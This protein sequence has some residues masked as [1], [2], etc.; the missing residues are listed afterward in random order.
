MHVELHP[1]YRD[2]PEA[3]RASELIS[4]CVHCG[5]CLATCPTYL[6]TADERDSP[7]GRIYLVKQLL[8][9]GTASSATRTHLDR[10]L[11]CRSCETTCPSGMQYGSLVDIGRGMLEQQVPRPLPER[12]FRALL[13][14][15]LTRPALFS[16][17]LQLGRLLAPL[18][19]APLAGKIPPRQQ[20]GQRP[21]AVHSRRVLLL[22][23][24]VQ[25]AATPTTNAALAR[26]LDRLGISL[27]TVAG[28][29]CCGAVNYHLG[30]H[31]DGLDNM[32]RNIDAWWPAVDAGAEA[33][34][35]SA[36]GCGS[37][38][39]DYGQLLAHDPAYADRARRIASLS[40]DAA[41][42]LAG[43][44][45]QAL[46]VDS[47]QG[48]VAVHTPCSQ[49]HGLKQPRLVQRILSEA[50]FELSA[51]RDDHLCCG[52]AGTYSILQRER[53]ER[54][55][56]RKLRALETGQPQ[57]IVTANVGCQ[58]HL[59]EQSRAPVRHWLELLDPDPDRGH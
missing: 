44:D 48:P 17:L 13:R 53:S 56:E 51:T 33:I 2:K 16:R 1:S 22:E 43:E 4:A 57:L 5:F 11:T 34:V 20:P 58:L 31:A 47:G 40:R 50:G 24:C 7:R 49:Y 6:D 30:A 46:A 37:L 39:A 27:E 45:L 41:E 29:G 35:S 25:A 12:G 52:S 54:L 14:Y 18:L 28:A 19:P 42:L 10:C 21:R 26:I 9:E 59:G 55:R 38:L 23:G 32:R 15:T 3:T 8:E 36:T